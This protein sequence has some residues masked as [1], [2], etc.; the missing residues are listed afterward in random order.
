MI[1]YSCRYPDCQKRFSQSSNLTAHLKNH[2]NPDYA[3]SE[4]EEVID[5]LEE[6]IGKDDVDQ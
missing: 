6:E 1:P 3:A 2:Q 5:E 4:S